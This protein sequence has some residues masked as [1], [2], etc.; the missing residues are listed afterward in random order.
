MGPKPVPKGAAGASKKTEQKKKEKVIEDKTFGLKNKKG[1]KMQKF[2]QQ[3]QTQVKYGHQSARK[4]EE[5]KKL[6]QD[7]KDIKKIELKELNEIFRPVI[8]QKVE[9]GTDPKSVVC[10]FFKQGQCTKGDRC[11]FSHDLTA[12]RRA[13][14]RSMYVDMRDEG[15]DGMDDWDE[16]KLK[17]V[18]EMKHGEADQGK[19]KTDIIC[20]YFLDAVENSK[21]GWFWEC[22]NGIKCH[23]RHALPPGFVL[24]KD[25][26]KEGRDDGNDLTLEDLIEKERAALGKNL[27]RVTLETFLAWKKRKRQ[28]KKQAKYKDSE[29]KKAEYKAGR[30]TGISGREMFTFNPDL[31]VGD[32]MDEGDEAFDT[33]NLKSEDTPDDTDADVKVMEIRDD[34]WALEED[35]EASDEEELSKRSCESPEDEENGEPQAKATG[36]GDDQVDSVPIDE[37]LFA[38]DDEDLQELEEQMEGMDLSQQPHNG[39]SVLHS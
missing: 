1:A 7:K 24:K 21:Y 22:P 14:K 29:R 3:V 26:K 35:G 6:Q 39:Y 28:E 15:T 2:V 33:S 17:E 12:E 32:Q 36:G 25:R 19:I 9:K 38:E 27:T 5:L 34:M 20:K 23:Y 16:E 4:M 8:V 37:D 18:V 31:A 10:A 11:K 13:E 30:N